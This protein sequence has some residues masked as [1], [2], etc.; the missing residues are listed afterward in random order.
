MKLYIRQRVFTWR[1]KYDITDAMENP[2]YH[3]EGEWLAFGARL[4]LC[5]PAGRELYRVERELFH[6]LPRYTLFHGERPVASIQKQFTLFGH[7]LSVD[8]Q[9][10]LLEMEGSVFG[11]EFQILRNG[12]VLAGVDKV[13]LSWGDTYELAISDRFPDPAF[14]CA[15]VIA[16]DNCVHNEGNG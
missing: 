13:L 8:S 1:D 10:G 3:V 9:Y 2:V 5:D 14:L 12:E 16:I 15:L 6:F 11:W 4:H 7:N